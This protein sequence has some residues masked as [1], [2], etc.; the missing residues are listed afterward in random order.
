[1]ANDGDRARAWRERDQQWASEAVL[2]GLDGARENVLE[3]I[4]RLRPD[5]HDEEVRDLYNAAAALGRT[6]AELDVSRVLVAETLDNLCE[7]AKVGRPAWLPGAKAAL[8]EA[9]VAHREAR[10]QAGERAR[11]VEPVVALED[12][13]VAVFAALEAEDEAETRAWA[14]ALVSKLA[15]RRVKRIVASGRPGA[16]AALADAAAIVGIAIDA[17]GAGPAPAPE[18]EPPAPKRR[19]WPFG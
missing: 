10:A 14:D 11:W 4:A 12:G 1:M 19:F 13:R 7:A 5:A 15:K 2:T 17:P 3:G 8:I 16:L 18:P 9:F 6:M